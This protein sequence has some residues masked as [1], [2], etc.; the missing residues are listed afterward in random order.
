MLDIASRPAADPFDSHPSEQKHMGADGP[1]V[2]LERVMGI[3]LQ[4]MRLELALRAA[5]SRLLTKVGGSTS[6]SSTG[7][8]AIPFDSHPSEQKHM[9]ADGPH[10]FLERVMGI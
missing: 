9:G 3:L 1:H 2:F 8:T 10:V 6:D 4:K 5:F 7:R